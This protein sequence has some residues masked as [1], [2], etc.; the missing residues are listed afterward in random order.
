M[1][2]FHLSP[3]TIHD[4]QDN[5]NDGDDSFFSTSTP[6]PV[7]TPASIPIPAPDIPDVIQDNCL[8]SI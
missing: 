4:E 1:E 6:A 3:M 5:F 2:E 7:S 8:K